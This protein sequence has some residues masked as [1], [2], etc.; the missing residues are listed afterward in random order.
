MRIE[1]IIFT[2]TTDI[3]SLDTDSRMQIM[4]QVGFYTPQISLQVDLQ[5]SYTTLNT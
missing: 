1:N 5:A 4:Q 2:I 3:R